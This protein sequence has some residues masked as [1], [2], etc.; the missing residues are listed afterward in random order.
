VLDLLSIANPSRLGEFSARFTFPFIT[1][2]AL[3]PSRGTC[4]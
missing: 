1:T 4:S 2:E 3:W